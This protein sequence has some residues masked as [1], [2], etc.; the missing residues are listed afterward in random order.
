[1]ARCLIKKTPTLPRPFGRKRMGEPS[2]G[3]SENSHLGKMGLTRRPGSTQKRVGWA[4]KRNALRGSSATNSEKCD[5]K[6]KRKLYEHI[7]SSIHV[8]GHIQWYLKTVYL[9]TL[10]GAFEPEGAKFGSFENSVTGRRRRVCMH[11]KI[12][13]WSRCRFF[14][15][16]HNVYIMHGFLSVGV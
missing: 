6:G 3:S 8:F 14:L 16:F 5:K 2:G 4:M 1:M 12:N 9:I 15:V 13:L 10:T 11:V 7:T